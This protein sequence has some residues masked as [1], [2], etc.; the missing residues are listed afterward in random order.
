MKEIL[1]NIALIELVSFCNRNN[2]P[3]NGHNGEGSKV[4]KRG[5]GFIYDLVSATTGKMIASV[6]FHKH[7]L[8]SVHAYAQT[9]ADGR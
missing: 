1:H 2:I 4:V 9:T 6:Q 7:A 3:P 5:R 8:P